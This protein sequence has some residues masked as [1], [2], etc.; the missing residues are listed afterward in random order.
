MLNFD[1]MVHDEPIRLPDPGAEIPSSPAMRGCA[2]RV[3]LAALVVGNLL[4]MP[5]LAEAA[6]KGAKPVLAPSPAAS[7]VPA[8]AQ[9]GAPP[10]VSAYAIANR[11]HLEAASKAGHTPVKPVSMRRTHQTIGQGQ[12]P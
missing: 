6:A 9:G 2:R 3:A 7:A 12:R 4:L 5:A 10:R 11:Q 8:T 1:E